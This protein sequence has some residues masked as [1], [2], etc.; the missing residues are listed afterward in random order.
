MHLPDD[1]FF[2]DLR[3]VEQN[4]SAVTRNRG[5]DVISWLHEFVQEIE[6]EEERSDILKFITGSHAAAFNRS[7][8]VINTLSAIKL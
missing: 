4:L 8:R 6:T 3:P 7:I 5:G 1:Y 2:Y